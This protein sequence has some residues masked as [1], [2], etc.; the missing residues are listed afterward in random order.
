MVFLLSLSNFLPYSAQY[1]QANETPSLSDLELTQDVDGEEHK[2]VEKGTTFTFN[3]DA[4]I[5][6]DGSNEGTLTILN[7]VDK[8]LAIENVEVVVKEEEEAEEEESDLEAVVEG[9]DVSLELTPG[10]SRWPTCHHE[11]YRCFSR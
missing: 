11:D 10:H 5:P 4:L 2:E 3:V 7:Q 6:E 9:Q 1:A 8:Q